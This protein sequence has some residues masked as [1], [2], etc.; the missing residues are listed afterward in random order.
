MKKTQSQKL[1]IV[2]RIVK[3]GYISTPWAIANMV[4]TKL[5]TR[6][7]EIERD[8]FVTSTRTRIPW[9]KD[10]CGTRYSYTDREVKRL[11]AEFGIDT[12]S[13]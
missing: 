4:T 7:G 2:K 3:M 9:G 10:S 8:H 13:I 6:I 11:G 1:K 5:S 12:D